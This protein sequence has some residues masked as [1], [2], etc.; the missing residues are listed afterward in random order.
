MGSD[1]GIKR[2]L[3]S[4]RIVHSVIGESANEALLSI[5]FRSINAN[6]TLLDGWV[7]VHHGM[8]TSLYK[9]SHSIYPYQFY[10]FT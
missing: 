2:T 8:E 9:L 10:P 1:S 7:L 5:A 3:D 4:T 6:L